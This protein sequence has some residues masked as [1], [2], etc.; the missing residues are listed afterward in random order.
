VNHAP[1]RRVPRPAP[2]RHARGA[3]LAVVLALLAA[4][5]ALS[6]AIATSAALEFAMADRG[7]A[8]LRAAEAADAGLAAALRARAWSA[9]DPWTA[10]GSL[11]GGGDW[12]VEARLVAA[13][14]DPLGGPVD[15]RFE[16]ESHGRHGAAHVRLVQALDITGALPGDPRLAGWRRLESGP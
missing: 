14:V 13:R 4:G 7:A 15:W 16:I 3:V 6:A 12:Q 1:F 10:A 2:P 5:M 9:S 11:D 8:R